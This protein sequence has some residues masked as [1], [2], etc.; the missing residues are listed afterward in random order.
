MTAVLETTGTAD[1]RA[2]RPEPRGRTDGTRPRTAVAIIGAGPRGLGVLER[3]T[4]NAADGPG[5]PGL[6]VHLVDPWAPGSGRI[7]RRGQAP[8]LWMNSTAA[9]VTLWPD[10]TVEMAGP[11]R[12]G[13]TLW[14]WI[15]AN[16]DELAADPEV[17]PAIAGLHPGSFVSR[18]VQ[19]R[20]LG[21]VLDRVLA[22]LPA[23]VRVHLHRD[24]AVDITDPA[25]DGTDVPTAVRQVVRLDSG[26]TL[27]VD[28]VV[29]AQGHLDTGP[30]PAERARSE[31][32]DRHGL[33]YLPPAYTADVD[34]SVVPE[35][36]DVLV[37]GLGLAFID[38]V[39]VLAE[40]RGGR[41]DRAADGTL[42]YTASGREPV[43]YA[44]SRRGVPYHAKISYPFPARRPPV[45][46]FFTP[47]AFGPGSSAVLDI[48]TDVWPRL[49]KDLGLAHYAELFAGH[50]ERV[51]GGWAP[52]LDAFSA[53]AWGTPGLER[54]VAAAVPDVADRLDLARLA[55]PFADRVFTGPDDVQD[56]V[57]DHVAADLARRSDPA[58]SSDAA[59]FTA[60]LTVYAVLAGLVRD[61]RIPPQ[62][63][64]REVE[65]R[66]HAFFSFVA[67]GPPPERLEQVLALS[68]AG[69]VRFLGP[70]LRIVLDEERGVFSASTAL[71]P[72]AF[73]ARTLI[74]AR[75]PPASVEDTTDPLLR[76][77][78]DRG[79]AMNAPG[80]GKLA[81]DP[82]QRVLRT[83]GVPEPARYAL[84]PWVAGNGWAPAF[85]RPRLN[86][87]F[88]RQ[89]DAL[90][91][92]VLAAVGA[93]TV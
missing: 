7:W 46:R 50:P 80:T 44:G 16:H 62:V 59:V 41:F 68:R 67:S 34:A 69:V 91:R 12:P 36:E 23:S 28:A 55:R 48:E 26:A 25:D 49:A 85:P 76:A 51:R 81:V 83:D 79:R 42:A 4:A 78:A 20:Y 88:F 73:S 11:V 93:R 21:A 40:S 87:G 2:G 5:E 63:A 92:T 22:E 54:V 89:D 65:S 8:L 58:F 38:W 84:G 77:L 37:S 18:S 53:Q 45:P 47:A 6:D 75:L 64:A 35:R 9:D 72:Q 24:R 60:L 17:G 29:L 19:A 15:Q 31:F 70:D 61:G 43:L 66:F 14:E 3:L 52:F 71:G 27:T 90:A 30:G 82:D 56:A 74:D 10:E 86:G 39:V 32:A 33:T 13:P 57:W 1:R